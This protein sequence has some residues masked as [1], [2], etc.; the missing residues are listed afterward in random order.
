MDQLSRFLI[1]FCTLRFEC[2][3]S[4]VINEYHFKKKKK[5]RFSL[6]Y[7]YEEVY[8]ECWTNFFTFFNKE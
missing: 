7:K 1:A 5:K 2:I 8:R 3:L 6:S 4:L